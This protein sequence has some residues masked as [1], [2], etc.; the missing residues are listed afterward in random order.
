LAMPQLVLA[1]D[2]IQEWGLEQPVL[3]DLGE[4]VPGEPV[5]HA[6]SAPSGKTVA[7]VTTRHLF[8]VDVESGLITVVEEVPGRGQLAMGRAGVFGQDEG[9]RLWHFDVAAG[10]IRR[11]AVHLPDGEWSGPLRWA[12][13]RHSGLL[14]TADATGQL[15]SFDE[16]KGFRTLGRAHLAPVGPMAMVPDGRLFG[17]CGDEMANLFCCDTVSGSV[18]NLGV[19]ASI[20]EQ[21]RYGYQF[22]GAV[23][24]PDGEIV[25]GEDDNG[26][27]LWL[28]FPKI[29]G[30][31]STPLTP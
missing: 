8:T 16:N 28:Y 30:V 3:K 22:G 9:T 13:D 11:A 29:K 18:T 4:C 5:V 23:A 7:G 14:F 2:W 17:F 26:G 20:L 19:A 10:H 1:E 21:R 31:S 24:G 6:I 15:F 12:R 25:F 27:H